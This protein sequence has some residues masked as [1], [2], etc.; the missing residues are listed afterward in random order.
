MTRSLAVLQAA[1][2]QWPPRT[3][4]ETCTEE[5]QAAFKRDG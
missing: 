1:D 5:L 3:A 2:L 4:L